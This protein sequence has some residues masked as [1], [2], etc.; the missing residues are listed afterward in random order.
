[1]SYTWFETLKYVVTESSLTHQASMTI[2]RNYIYFAP[3]SFVP[4]GT[5]SA[6]DGSPSVETLGYSLLSL[7]GLRAASRLAT[8]EGT[9]YARS[10]GPIESSLGEPCTEARVACQLEASAGGKGAPG[11]DGC[12]V[13]QQ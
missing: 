11:M 4:T 10:I 3:F 5:P 9:H 13:L 8:F 6:W 12:T 2:N 7:P 1:M